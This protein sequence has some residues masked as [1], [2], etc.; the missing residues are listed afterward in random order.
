M[1][2]S[3]SGLVPNAAERVIKRN[4]PQV[5]FDSH[6]NSCPLT[7]FIHQDGILYILQMTQIL[8]RIDYKIVPPSV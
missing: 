7:S 8:S 4:H 6:I 2:V 5:H 1:Q 3:E